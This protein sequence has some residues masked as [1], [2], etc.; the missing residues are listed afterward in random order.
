M[1]AMF[2]SMDL[3]TRDIDFDLFEFCCR[4]LRENDANP[5]PWPQNTSIPSLPPPHGTFL[6]RPRPPRPGNGVV[7]LPEL[8]RLA[9]PLGVSSANV[10]QLFAERPRTRRPAHAARAGAAMGRDRG[11][12]GSGRRWGGWSGELKVSTT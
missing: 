7:D 4:D 2:L 8:A 12:E 5:R 6:Q 10:A 11:V 9:T 3:L 1:Q